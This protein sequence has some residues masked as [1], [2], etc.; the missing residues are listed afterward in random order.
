MVDRLQNTIGLIG[1]GNMSTALAR[2]WLDAGLIRPEQIF[3]SAQTEST[4]NRFA[5][6]F[7]AMSF[8][9]NLEVINRAKVLVLAVKAPVAADVLGK[10][11]PALT[12]QHLLISVVAGLTLKQIEDLVGDG[13]RVVRVMPNTPCLVG[14][15][16]SAY[17]LGRSCADIDRDTVEKLF[18]AVGTTASVPE[19]QMDAVT[20][21]SGCGPAFVA[22][23]IDA[24]TDGGILMGL[25]N[26]VAKSL[27]AQTVKGTA[28]LVMEGNLQP[29]EIKTMV[30]S[31]GGATCA[32]VL[33]LEQNATRASLMNAV[34]MATQR[35]SELGSV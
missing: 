34:K 18:G 30:S 14:A 33:E 25:P 1:A 35:A 29:S 23:I 3:A 5:S 12:Q 17:C 11:R 22:M 27:A 8:I 28:E 2:G 21:L 15:S 7:G 31:P 19:K 16:A 32:G 20:G 24:L 10:L 26:H 13:C 4:R 6:Q 9:D